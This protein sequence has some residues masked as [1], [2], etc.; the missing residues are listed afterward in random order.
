M[1]DLVANV[2]HA[3]VPLGRHPGTLEIEHADDGLRW[4]V[5][6]AESRADVRDAVQRGDLKSASWRMVVKRDEWR[7]NVRHVHEVAELR[8]VSVVTAAA[9]PA[10]SAELR[11]APE[12]ITPEE[13]PV[14]P[15]PKKTGATLPVE[16]RAAAAPTGTVESRVLDAFATV[17]KGEM[18]DLTHATAAPVEPDD[19]RTQLIDKYRT[20]SVVAESGVP[21][22]TTDR[23]AVTRPV[24]S[25]DITASFYDE[26][27]E[28]DETDPSFDDFTVPVKA[29]KTL[30]RGSSEAFEDSDPELLGI[31]NDNINTAMVLKGDRSLLVGN[32]STEPKGF[33]GLLNVTGTQSLAVGGAISWDHVVKAVGLLVEAMVPGPYAVLMGPRPATSLAL[34]KEQSGSNQYLSMPAGIPPV[35]NTGWFPVTTGGSPTTTVIVYAPGQQQIVLR[36]SVSILVDRSKGFSSDSVYVRGV[37]RLGLGVPHPQ[38]IVKL[39]GV[40]APAITA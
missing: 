39:T 36:K 29:I 38:S 22:I 15:Q 5:E 7:G 12:P 25:G 19:L 2:D 8:D 21:I 1:D 28:I 23:K 13:E 26:L 14:V 40:S 37:Y 35:F 9:Y 30:V 34:L 3:G 17:E 33:N 10:A 11:S 27:D 6:L 31:L 24:I 4:S 16:D 32:T 18:R 20:T